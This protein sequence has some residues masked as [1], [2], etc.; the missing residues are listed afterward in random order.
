ML[1]FMLRVNPIP[2]VELACGSAS[3]NNVLNSNT[4][5]LAARFMDDVVLPTPPFDG[6][7]NNFTH[8]IVK[9][10]Y[11]WVLVNNEIRE[12]LLYLP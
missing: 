9:K 7:S 10:I 2:D 4:A 12:Q 8:F 11:K 1:F 6:Q 5:K 3:T